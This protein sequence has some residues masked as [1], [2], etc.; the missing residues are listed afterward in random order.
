MQE[1]SISTP[2]IVREGTLTLEY[3]R[4]HQQCE[5]FSPEENKNTNGKR[6]PEIIREAQITG[7]KA[8]KIN[9]S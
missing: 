4:A 1:R 5:A 9:K 7:K 6:I 2:K 8:K 3:L